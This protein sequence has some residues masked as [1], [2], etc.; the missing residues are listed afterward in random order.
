[1]FF[2]KKELNLLLQESCS[3]TKKRA[4]TFVQH[5]ETSCLAQTLNLIQAQAGPV[6]GNQ[7]RQKA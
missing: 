5:V 1:M 6:F 4:P 7:F 3:K 2:E